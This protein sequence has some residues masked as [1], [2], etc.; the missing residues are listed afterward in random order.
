MRSSPAKGSAAGRSKRNQEAAS[1]YYHHKKKKA[2]IMKRERYSECDESVSKGKN[3]SSITG[4]HC[5]REWD[6]KNSKGKE[7]IIRHIGTYSG[8]GMGKRVT[9]ITAPQTSL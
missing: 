8:K 2:P 6:K 5:V 1:L 7:K 9:L 4:S 3:E